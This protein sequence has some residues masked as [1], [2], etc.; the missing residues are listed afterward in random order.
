MKKLTVL[1]V[2]L[3]MA[4]AVLG[5]TGSA[6]I[7]P[8]AISLAAYHPLI[9]IDYKPGTATAF[10]S[11]SVEIDIPPAFIPAPTTY[12]AGSNLS[13]VVMA[14]GVT[15]SVIAASNI[16]INGYAVTI[17]P[18]TL[19][20]DQEL[21]ITYGSTGGGGLYPPSA[22]GIYYFNMSE[23]RSLVSSF[24]A[25]DQQPYVYVTYVTINKSSQALSVKAG[26]TV[27]YYI[28]FGNLDTGNNLSQLSIWDTL[29]PGMTLLSSN[30]AAS[31]TGNNV[32]SWGT[33]TVLASA[34]SNITVVAQANPG[35]IN[36]GVNCV[37]YAS[38]S[39][40][41]PVKGALSMDTKKAI[42]VTGVILNT[43]I[44]AFPSSPVTNQNITVVMGITNAGNVAA[45][46]V[47]GTTQ[48]ISL[49]GSAAVYAGPT[50]NYISSLG[51]G[52]TAMFTW[53]YRATNAGTINFS[54]SSAGLENSSVVASAPVFSNNVL[55]IDPTPT[56]TS[57]SF[58][59]ATTVPPTN[60]PIVPTNTFTP[61][62]TAP[63]NTATAVNTQPI[64]PVYT[65]TPATPT[66]EPALPDKVRTD[67]NYINLSSGDRVEI[68]YTV[69]TYGKTYIRIYN[70]LGEEVRGFDESMMQAGTYSAYWDGTN[71]N[72]S[73]VGK[74][75]YFIDVT[76]PGG[77]TIKK[78]VVIK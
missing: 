64:T 38:V 25:L 63:A 26:D 41:H 73:K 43:V 28:N 1:A 58:P 77:R 56:Y 42:P 51:A 69:E 30:L 76:Q 7:S 57:T 72:G 45:S 39:A 65:V 40:I 23:K 12:S 16:Y 6:D 70:L 19:S 5:Q 53:I 34:S 37:N 4:G 46:M 33:G 10:T 8:T 15:Q 29:P 55:I 31:V 18:L 67:R 49:G 11:G 75:I 52:G 68:K 2:F 35:I 20:P 17:T 66:P 71:A 21:V 78:I 14:A 62:S 22:P 48:V 3:L 54:G 60:T 24:T 47:S 50:P 59:T 74:G 36:F 9:N 13:A 32:L 44:S 27:T 61:Q